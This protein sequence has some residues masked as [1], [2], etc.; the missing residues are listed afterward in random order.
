M[1]KKILHIGI[2]VKT[3][4]EATKTFEKL[5]LAFEGN[6]EV[7]GEKVKVAFFKVGESRIELLEP[8]SPD[9]AIARFLDKRGEGVHHI[10]IQTEDLK[11]RIDELKK[12]GFRFVTDEI[13]GAHGIKAAFLHPKNTNG[14]LFE[15]ASASY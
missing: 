4:K 11:K 2:A 15:I 7:P 3:L 14:V 10:C 1:Y 6:E 9:S 13:K 12:R 5:G 8:T